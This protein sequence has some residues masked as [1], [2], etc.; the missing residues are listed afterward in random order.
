MAIIYPSTSDAAVANPNAGK[1]GT[2]TPPIPHYPNGLS[3][4]FNSGNNTSSNPT[5]A[6]SRDTGSITVVGAPGLPR[7][8][9]QD[10]TQQSATSLACDG[11]TPAGQNGPAS[12][13]LDEDPSIR[14]TGPGGQPNTSPVLNPQFYGPAPVTNIAIVGRTATVTCVNNF[15]VGMTVEFD[16]TTT[17]TASTGIQLDRIVGQITV[18]SPSSATVQM[19]PTP[20]F[21][22]VG[23]AAETGW[24]V[25]ST[26]QQNAGLSIMV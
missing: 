21:G 23:S 1:A 20:S 25:P 4:L 18:V 24:L 13:Y 26:Q 3:G 5:L 14:W 19:P 11:R 2:S 17:T 12:N 8:K 10:G 22:T 7:Y 15:V 9:A 16:G 6:I